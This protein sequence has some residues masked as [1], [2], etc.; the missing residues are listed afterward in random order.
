MDAT[1]S[2]CPIKQGIV[3]Q[4]NI[5]QHQNQDFLPANIRQ[6]SWLLLYKGGNDSATVKDG[7]DVVCE[8]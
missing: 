2:R 7:G 3:L 6:Y 1:N 5:A 8:C 4:L